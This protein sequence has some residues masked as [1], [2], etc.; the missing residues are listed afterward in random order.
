MRI[1][2]MQAENIKKL[3]VVEIRPDGSLVQI[4]GGN[5]EGKSSVLDA[6]FYALAGTKGIPS[7]PVRK[8][9]AKAHVKLD[10]GEFTVT[11]RFTAEGGTSLTVEAKGTKF[12]SP[13]RILDDIMGTLTF[14]PLE[15]SRM[16]PRQQLE[17]LR[18]MVHLDVDIDAIDR[19]NK[20]DF[21]LRTDVNRNVKQLEAQIAAIE[22]PER[23]PAKVDVALLVKEMT[24]ASNANVARAN[25]I[26]DVERHA[27]RIEE[28]D[29]EA[30]TL[31]DQAEQLFAKAA[32]VRQDAEAE[33]ALEM[34][35]IPSTIDMT[36]YSVKLS[37][38]RAAEQLH[39]AADRRAQLQQERDKAEA[40][41]YS[42]TQAIANR[43]MTKA[44]AIANANMPVKGLSFDQNEVLFN[45]VPFVQAS[46]AEQLRVS[47]AIAMAANP[48][49]RVL[50]IKD[51]SLLDNKNL[52]MLAKMADR[53]DYQI[54]IEK[55]NQEGPRPSI[56]MED[57]MVKVIHASAESA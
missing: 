14:D 46:S 5:G 19:A 15:F 20:S 38:A 54:W 45:N 10:L 11:R 27:R 48:K 32:R 26:A 42:L 33:R 50:R 39:Q 25:L 40:H 24:E 22:L 13:Q 57:G 21:E 53:Y 17:T 9:T 43:A 56:V 12:S 52:A 44:E 30:Q 37:T 16:V 31:T 7:E 3:K 4:T 34:P 35:E 18:G 49:L 23:M 8:G 29:I 6:I 41:S 36:D 55:I 47:V 2:S 28:L 1:L 51:G